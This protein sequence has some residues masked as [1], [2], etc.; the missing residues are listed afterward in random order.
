MPTTYS[1]SQGVTYA[2]LLPNFQSVLNVLPDNT[3]KLIAPRD[4]RD[5]FFTTWESIVFK[6]TKLSSSGNEYIGIDDINLTQK[7]YFGKKLV[8]GVEVLNDD[9]LSNDTD[10]YFYNN[11]AEPQLKPNGIVNNRIKYDHIVLCKTFSENGKCKF[12]NKCK[13]RHQQR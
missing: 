8:G 13:F 9:L 5:S 6:K 2:E 1:I 7:V 3:Q 11:K 4:V 12:G 10:F